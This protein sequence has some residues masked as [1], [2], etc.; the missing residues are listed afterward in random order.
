[1]K[2]SASWKNLFDPATGFIRAKNSD[3]SWVQPF[4]PYL[5][6][7]DEIKAMYTE[8]NAWQHS[9]FVPQDVAGLAK[10]H[11][12]KDKFVQ[13]LDSLFSVSSEINGA[14]RSPDVSGLIGQY[15]HGNEP[16]H[17]IAYM[18]SFIGDAWKTQERVKMIVD[19]MY[20]D[21]PDGYAGNEDCGQMSAWGVWSIMGMYPANPSGGQYV[22]GSPMTDEAIITLPSKRKMTI[23]ANN[24]S[25][26]NIYIQSVR[27]NGKPYNKTYISHATLL[28]GGTLIFTM[29]PKPNKQF[30]SKP[31][32]W[33]SSASR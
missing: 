20:H 3:G 11:G 19:S 9:F 4:D 8:G 22:F 7:H 24:R 10:A 33:P 17:H 30:G 21:Q 6:E 31:E 26:E 18:Y 13:K 16:S 25:M 14:N 32:S 5:S 2:R 28:N 29:G 23:R 15:A 1:M 27:L 12:G